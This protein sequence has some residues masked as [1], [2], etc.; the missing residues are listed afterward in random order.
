MAEKLC[1][2]LI[3]FVLI[4][5]GV[6]VCVA[7]EAAA[8][9]AEAVDAGT[10]EAEVADVGAAAEVVTKEAKEENSQAELRIV[11]GALLQG[12]DE[13]NRNDA[14]D[15]LLHRTD[16]ESRGIL[17]AALG[18]KANVQARKAICC[19][20]IK[21]RENGGDLSGVSDFVEPLLVMLGDS[22]GDD[23]KL[24]AEAL[25]LYPYF[26]VR[27]RLGR[28]A[29]GEGAD[30]NGRVNAIYA[31]S[32][33]PGEKG[34]ILEL[35]ELAG[36]KD[37]SVAKAASEAL[38]YWVPKGAD[39][40][41]VV[42]ELEKKSPSE[43]IRDRM[44]HQRKEM[45]RLEV[46]LSKWRQMYLK[47]LDKEYG[48]T[49]EAKRA[50]LLNEKLGSDVVDVKLWAIGKISQRTV[51]LAQG[52]SG[53]R[54]IG[55]VSDGDSRVRLATAKVLAK[56]TYLNPGTKLLEQL[57]VE[58]DGD[59]RLAVFEALGE[60]CYFAFS[61]GST[62]KLPN[63]IRLQTLTEAGEY[64]KQADAVKA[65]MGAEVI[66]K[67]LGP[68]G[69]SDEVTNK[70]LALVAKR[71]GREKGKGSVGEGELL[72]IMAELCGQA[73][74]RDKASK[75]FRQSFIDGLEAKNSDAVRAASVAGLINIDKTAALVELRTRAI[76]DDGSAVVRRPMID[77]AAEVGKTDD[78]VWLV[79]KRDAANGE[80]VA[81]W[82]ATKS[83]L[84][85]QQA[86]V[87][88]E[89]IDKL[90]EA[91]ASDE[92]VLGLLEI[93][94]KKAEGENNA[95]VLGLA[96]GKLR[97]RRATGYLTAGDF[98]KVAEVITARLAEGDMDGSDG[99]AVLVEGYLAGGAGE[100]AKKKLAAVLGQI[101][102]TA[103]LPGWAALSKGWQD[104]VNPKPKVVETP[105]VVEVKA[106]V[107]K[108]VEVKTTQPPATE[109]KKAAADTAKA[110][111]PAKG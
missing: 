35:V 29:H 94:V 98:A 77:A 90:S 105:A 44:D 75:L 81:V 74:N 26:Q 80:G 51:K 18:D 22:Q 9:K 12:P 55:L 103:E 31:L 68:N 17:L 27:D 41:S 78:I 36:D 19:G 109:V 3:L 70:N 24:A 64:I 10:V 4:A 46:E 101:K 13:Q 33:R 106:A 57:K 47:S 66:R 67:L 49:E 91:G 95:E 88:L 83:I 85:R 38:P 28:M 2:I 5:G 56:M 73:S 63:D 1:T 16:A 7:E 89:W 87:V 62:I 110:A 40:A 14:A 58:K 50:E 79:A 25:L 100:D 6:R 60:A 72:G 99:L 65:K 96:K 11:K 61:P 42:R 20:L 53:E 30:K 54:L 23:A 107:E 104:K 37:E 92:Q 39:R 86:T 82:Q 93:A 21:S 15:V 76:Y 8:V 48:E 52:Q 59:V 43:I 97:V 84:V 111:G 45:R 71:Y 32:L 69:L 102:L 34:V 108:P